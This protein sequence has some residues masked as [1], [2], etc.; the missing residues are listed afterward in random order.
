MRTYRLDV[1]PRNFTLLDQ[2]VALSKKYNVALR[3]M[4]YPITTDAAVLKDT[5]YQMAKRYANDIKIW[6]IG[7][8]QD[9]DR[10]GAQTRINS[11]VPMY[12]GIK[13]ASDEMGAN[14][15]T[16]INV[17][18]CNSDD[19]S[20]TGRCPGD[21]N[22]DMWFL[23]MAKASGWNFD[24][25]SFH[26]YTFFSDKGYWYDMYLGQMRNMATK[27]NTKVFYNEMNCADIYQGNTTGGFAGDKGCYDAV[28]QILVELNKNY[29]DVVQEIS[30]YELLDEPN[31]SGAEAHFGLLYDINTPKE[32]FNMITSFAK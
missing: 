2:M 10:S 21:K 24:Y 15:K 32:Y 20:A 27:Y 23:D 22:G 16:T 17:M 8:E 25:I 11:L 28:Q 30:M 7:N 6:E 19:T 31:M 14:L 4:V 9:F 29:K 13:Q 18:A 5:A 12:Q 3:P 26:Y 1:D